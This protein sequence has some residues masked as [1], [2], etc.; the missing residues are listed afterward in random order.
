MRQDGT[1]GCEQ[2][3]PAPA[4]ATATAPGA[5]SWLAAVTVSGLGAA[6]A[7]WAAAHVG[8]GPALVAAAPTLACAVAAAIATPRMR[9]GASWAALAV[10]SL[11]G[12]AAADRLNTALHSSALSAGLCTV[13]LVAAGIAFGRRETER[14]GRDPVAEVAGWTLV[15]T[16][17]MV[18]VSVADLTARLAGSGFA[19]EIAGLGLLLPAVGLLPRQASLSRVAVRSVLALTF[20]LG[21]LVTDWIAAAP[22]RGGLGFGPGPA[23]A[24]LAVIVVA[25]LV[26]LSADEPRAG[27]HLW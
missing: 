25:L 27:L 9:R 6:G 19:W 10:G 20:A 26:P 22:G 7:D 23:A 12:T 3:G 24:A 1:E 5:E 21:A 11:A 2:S 8:A 17:V 16:T 14:Q 4:G 18:G 13:A 15:L